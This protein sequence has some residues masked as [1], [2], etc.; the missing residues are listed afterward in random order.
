MPQPSLGNLDLFSVG[1]AIASIGILGF[2]VFLNNRRS[3]TNKTFL[4]FS[5]ITIIWGI[6]NYIN[7]KTGSPFLVL[8][9]LRLLV[10]FSVLHAFSFF[11]LFY[12]F[13]FFKIKFFYKYK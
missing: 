1:I 5:L 12:F 13:P 2:A 8:W 7:Y 4:A 11:L 9:S 3:I 10:F 6:F